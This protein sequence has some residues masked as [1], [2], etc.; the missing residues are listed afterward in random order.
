MNH[1]HNGM[2][3]SNNYLS[4][5]LSTVR[6]FQDSAKVVSDCEGL[7]YMPGVTHTHSL[8]HNYYLQAIDRTILCC[9]TILTQ[10]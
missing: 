8:I 7:G 2:G 4:R 1:V 9:S 6:G 10:I 3:T 5:D